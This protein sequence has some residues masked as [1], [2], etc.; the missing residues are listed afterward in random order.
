MTNAETDNLP[1]EIVDCYGYAM[2][3]MLDI[4]PGSKMWWGL[5]SLVATSCIPSFQYTLA[6]NAHQRN[7]RWCRRS[8]D[9]RHHVVSFEQH[10]E[11]GGRCYIWFG[12]EDGHTAL[13]CASTHHTAA[14]EY[15]EG[16]HIFD[17]VSMNT[18]W[19]TK[20]VYPWAVNAV[21]K[22]QHFG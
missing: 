21:R 18:L 20:R 16:P 13:P 1:S 15:S 8:A 7:R 12:V 22:S 14:L 11:V 3:W 5:E 9:S 10:K 6:E 17:V 2:H 4:A 19:D